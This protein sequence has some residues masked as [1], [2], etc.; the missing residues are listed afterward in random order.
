MP[1]RTLSMIVEGEDK[2]AAALASATNNVEA[3]GFMVDR[4]GNRM[5]TF[6]EHVEQGRRE[7]EAI[8]T[9]AAAAAAA[10]GETASKSSSAV[11]PMMYF[12]SSLRLIS[13]RSAIAVGRVARLGKMVLDAGDKA[14]ASARK[15]L[16]AGAGI[17]AIAA[18]AVYVGRAIVR[19]GKRI[20]EWSGLSERSAFSLREMSQ[21]GQEAK[22]TADE[23]AWAMERLGPVSERTEGGMRLTADAVDEL[24]DRV[25]YLIRKWGPLRDEEYAAALAAAEH[26]A[27]MELEARTAQ[28]IVEE[29]E[30][31]APAIDRWEEAT[32]TLADATKT[33]LQPAYDEI[34]DGLTKL[35]TEKGP[36][37]VEVLGKLADAFAPGLTLSIQDAATRLETFLRLTFTNLLDFEQRWKLFKELIDV[38][39]P[40]RGPY[41]A[42]PA[43]RPMP[44]YPP[45]WQYERLEQPSYGYQPGAQ[46]VDVTS[47]ITVDVNVDV[48]ARVAVTGDIQDEMRRVGME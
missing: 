11:M 48:P 32:S 19:L 7:M 42:E 23:L 24:G 25:S 37:A 41:Y 1:T 6:A 22:M 2:S 5:M 9:G 43:P 28:K 46:Q 4:A 36:S 21:A 16:L 30:K 40:T 31:A 34:L 10:I 33:R 44:A 8:P 12:A 47:H 35:V 39:E 27:V 17:I 45:G 20:I 14:G 29:A 26:Q 15:W 13:R 3:L 18:I 38:S